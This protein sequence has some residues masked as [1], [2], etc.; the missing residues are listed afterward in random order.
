M[1]NYCL[2]CSLRMVEYTPNTITASQLFLC[3]N[4]GTVAI[5]QQD[6][7]EIALFQLLPAKDQTREVSTR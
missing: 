6:T 1:E 3:P 7:G 2:K 4:C 5:P